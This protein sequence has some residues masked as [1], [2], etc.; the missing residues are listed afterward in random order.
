MPALWELIDSESSLL[1][2]RLFI[3]LLIEDDYALHFV[4]S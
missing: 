2:I 1:N 3:F 4:S